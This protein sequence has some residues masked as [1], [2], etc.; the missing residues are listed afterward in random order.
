M[1]TKPTTSS[2]ESEN[3]SGKVPC[4]KSLN[5]FAV[6]GVMQQPTTEASRGQQPTALSFLPNSRAS[7]SNFPLGSYPTRNPR[8]QFNSE[9]ASGIVDSSPV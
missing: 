3:N 9:S 2:N 6:V 8:V 1:N 5:F 4:K 7:V